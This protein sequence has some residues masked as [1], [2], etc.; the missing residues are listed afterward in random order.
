M[1]ILFVVEAKLF[2][3][4]ATTIVVT[5]ELTNVVKLLSRFYFMLSYAKCSFRLT[6]GLPLCNAATSRG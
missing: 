3:T 6:C 4:V 1:V 2:M 5:T